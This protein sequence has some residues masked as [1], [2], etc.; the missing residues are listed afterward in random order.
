MA[1]ISLNEFVMSGAKVRAQV[2]DVLTYAGHVHGS[3]GNDMDYAIFD[4]AV[5]GYK[6]FDVVFEHPELLEREGWAGGDS[7]TGTYSFEAKKRGTTLV[8]LI[9]LFRGQEEAKHDVEVIVG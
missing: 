6:G 9:H 5:V 2:G 1:T 8:R 7:A 3:V 4:S